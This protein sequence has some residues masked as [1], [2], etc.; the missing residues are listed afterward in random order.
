MMAQMKQKMEMMQQASISSTNS[1]LE[2]TLR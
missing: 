2:M 1:R